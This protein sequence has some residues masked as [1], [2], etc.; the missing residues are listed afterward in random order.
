MDGVTA[1]CPVCRVSLSRSRPTRNRFAGTNYVLSYFCPCVHIDANYNLT[2]SNHYEQSSCCHNFPFHAPTT[3]VTSLWNMANCRRTPTKSTPFLSA[4]RL[5]LVELICSHSHVR[6]LRRISTCKYEP[7]GCD[8]RDFASEVRAHEKV[9][10]LK[11]ATPKQIL[12]MVLAR[13]VVWEDKV[14][15][16]EAKMSKYVEVCALRGM[17][18]VRNLKVTVA[19]DISVHQSPTVCVLFEQALPQHHRQGR[20]D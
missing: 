4:A 20:P 10:D 6:C 19:D 8:W 9:C 14:K 15:V 1:T 7:L 13:N 11:S 17:L 3:V 12:A 16:Q 2:C 5:T 18:V